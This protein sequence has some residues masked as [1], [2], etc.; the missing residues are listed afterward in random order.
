M[1]NKSE[2]KHALEELECLILIEQATGANSDDEMRE[3]KL[4][5]LVDGAEDFFL[6]EALEDSEGEDDLLE[7]GYLQ[8]ASTCYLNHESTIA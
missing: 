4:L 6:H 7:H 8:I 5:M 2:Q 1:P 3:A